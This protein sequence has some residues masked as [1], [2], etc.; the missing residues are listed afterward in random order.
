MA[1]PN[2]NDTDNAQRRRTSARHR[3]LRVLHDAENLRDLR[4]IQRPRLAEMRRMRARPMMCNAPHQ[5]C[6]ASDVNREAD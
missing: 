6:G 4:G 2:A 5:P 1:D 3:A